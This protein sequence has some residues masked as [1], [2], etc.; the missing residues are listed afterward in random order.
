MSSV[1]K[2]YLS[3]AFLGLSVGT[4]FSLPT[5]VDVLAVIEFEKIEALALLGNAEARVEL[6]DMYAEGKHVAKDEAK[7]FSLYE[8][9][10]AQDYVKG[11]LAVAKSYY[12]GRGVTQ[13]YKKSFESFEKAAKLGSAEAQSSLGCMWRDGLGVAEKNLQQAA[14]WLQK[15]ADQGFDLAKQALA[16]VKKALK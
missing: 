2:K 13:D 15:S 6:G 12:F 5:V 7:A 11:H 4:C 14:D 1:F 8:K 10:A 9:A 3:L 16:D